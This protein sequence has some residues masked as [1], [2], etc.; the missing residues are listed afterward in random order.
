[1]EA[2][3][4]DRVSGVKQLRGGSFRDIKKRLTGLGVIASRDVSARAAPV[5]TSA[6]REAFDGAR[7]VYGAPRRVGVDGGTL[8]LVRTGATRATLGFTVQ[9]TTLRA[10]LGTR[11]AKYLIGRYRILPIGDRTAIPA[12][13]KRAIDVI[14]QDVLSSEW[15]RAA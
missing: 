5:I 12:K 4:G 8:S 10:R 13:W 11:W 14:V 2:L 7:D 6:L 3:R 1:M 9:G 15:R